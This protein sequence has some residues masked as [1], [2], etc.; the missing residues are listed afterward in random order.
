MTRV[1]VAGVGNVFFGDDGFG[2]HVAG[3]LGAA[4]L[5]EATRVVDFGIRGL[6]LAFELLSPPEL[7][8]GVAAAARG[9]AP[10]TL[11]VIDPD[12][13]GATE[14]PE[15]SRPEGHGMDLGAVFASLR[16]MGGTVPPTRIVGCEPLD[17]APGMELSAPVKNAIPPAITLIRQLIERGI[18]PCGFDAPNPP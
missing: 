7:L 3:S 14:A 1:L 12:D 11:Y 10:G 16:S 13:P 18:S 15:P 9:G 4:P 2:V 8:I 6:H 5:P 17:L